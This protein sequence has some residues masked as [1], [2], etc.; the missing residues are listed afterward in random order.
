M[1]LC[2]SDHKG[3]L[4]NSTILQDLTII[5]VDKIDKGVSQVVLNAY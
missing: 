1:K 4:S 3:H 5:R 2:L